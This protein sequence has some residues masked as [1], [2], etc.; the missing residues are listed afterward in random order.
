MNEE[1]AQ[2]ATI[3]TLKEA[4]NTEE[5]DKLQK[6][7][8]DLKFAL[9]ESTIVAT[10]DQTGKINFVNDKFCKI[11]QY[12]REELL[13]QDHRIINSGY[14]SK[15]F[16]R[17]LWTTI[18]G[19]KVWRGELR[20]RAK[21]GSIY[22][23]ATT[24]VPF[25][26]TDGKPYQYIAIR[27]DI[28][29]RKNAEKMVLEKE[30][31]LRS[32]L[33]TVPECIKLIDTDGRI[34]EINRAGL[35]MIEADSIEDV[36]EQSVEKFVVA[37][38]LDEFR[39]LNERTFHG[40]SGRMEF[41]IVGLKGTHRWCE[42]NVK[43][44]RDHKGEITAAL[45]VSADITQR[46]AAEAEMLEKNRLLE[47][48]HDAIF[49]W[50][51]DDG[52]IYWNKNAEQLYGY[53]Q[54][55][56]VG[57]EVYEILE[58]VYPDSFEV[59]FEELKQNRVWEGEI[60]HT[61]KTGK[62]IFTESR[63]AISESDEGVAIVLETTRD[64]TE[65]KQSDDR[66]R[67][68]ASLLEKSQDAILVCDLGFRILFWNK[69]AERIYGWQS[70]EV[71]GKELCE[72]ICNGDD[73][74]TEKARRLLKT[75]NELQEE[76]MHYTKDGKKITVVSRWTQVRNEQGQ[77]D[78]LL[79]INSDI[80]E[81]KHTEKQLYRAQRLE[82]IGT[83]AGGIAHDL[84]NVLSPILMAVEMLQSEESIEKAGE[85]WLSII[86]ENTER[87]ANLIRQVLTF[88]RGMEGERVNVQLRHLIKDLIKVL[89]ETLPKTI[90]VKYDIEPELY[91]VFADPTQIHQILMNLVVNARDAM[92]DGGTLT[93][94]ANNTSIDENYA[95]MNIEAEPGNYVLLTV[96]DTGEGMSEDVLN[97]IWDPFY[98][99]K[100]VG[101]GTGLGLSTALSIVKS[102]NGFIN[103]YS[104]PRIGT[105]FAIYL[106]ASESAAD[107]AERKE[108][109]PYPKGSGEIVLVVDDE[110]N[111]LQVT[112]ATLEKYGYKTL[113]ASDGTEAIAVYT[114]NEKIDLVITDMSMPY[115]DGA[116]TIRAL[117]KINP[118][119]KIISTSGLTNFQRADNKELNTNAF[120]LKPFSAEKLL[121]TIAEVLA[122]N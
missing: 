3:E 77:P 14:H 59:Y 105:Q 88:A 12:S 30:N 20:N 6:G 111:I 4:I 35:D 18:A 1:T 31:H 82:S 116:A 85:P 103:V 71:L 65:R 21:D 64:I 101:K 26:K 53:K 48:T 102:H 67:Q 118:Q 110:E 38:Y 45:A 104:E 54:E 27:H 16:I 90:T 39:R 95:W 97:R 69:G 57:K 73:S 44:F 112:T 75:D 25:L 10:T 2:T 107:M 40:E 70:D 34:L 109:A 79:L 84:N 36:Q 62:R 74:V 24:I 61:T 5:F 80:T 11:S 32:I 42:T 7:L 50:R 100:E 63:Q 106:P 86:G 91:L 9:D 8:G 94:K 17:E 55:E 114:Q 47:Q 93:I 113:T 29:N 52:I 92:P 120:L 78:Y 28:T 122:G 89:G 37:D 58:A 115:M 68:Q 22:W 19:G 23:V 117:R 119:L 81:L 121:T 99:T 60:Q 83:L 46:K 87:G 49:I 108:N 33:D 51:L 41:E 15:E 96:K 72:A 98:T 43:P 66:I 13:G 76:T 56:V